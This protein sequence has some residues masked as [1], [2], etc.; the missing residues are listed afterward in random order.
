MDTMLI[1]PLHR[2]TNS[3]GSSTAVRTLFATYSILGAQQMCVKGGPAPKK[4]AW[5]V[6]VLEPDYI[7][8]SKM[9]VQVEVEGGICNI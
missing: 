4:P 5:T 7:N 8:I 1:F 6:T 3:V 2:K 9:G